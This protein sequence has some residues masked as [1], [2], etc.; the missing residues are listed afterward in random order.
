MPNS[1]R[2][3]FLPKERERERATTTRSQTDSKA[4][5]CEKVARELT[6]KFNSR[7]SRLKSQ[8]AV[9]R[10]FVKIEGRDDEGGEILAL[11]LSSPS[12]GRKEREGG[13]R[14]PVWL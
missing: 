4:E 8:Q 9:V 12:F 6:D 14:L 7:W 3:R 5:A 11:G 1:S 10:F 2:T 13:E